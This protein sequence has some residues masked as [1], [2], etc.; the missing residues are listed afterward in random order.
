MS[1]YVKLLQ[2]NGANDETGLQKLF[3]KL[4]YDFLYG[5]SKYMTK[6]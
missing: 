2:F 4:A 5:G 3:E 6:I 1:L